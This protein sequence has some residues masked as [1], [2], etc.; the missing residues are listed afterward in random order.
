MTLFHDV[1]GT[2]SDGA[3]LEGR[4]TVRTAVDANFGTRYFAN[5]SWTTTPGGNYNTRTDRDVAL[6]SVGVRL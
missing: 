3:F 4:I 1:N 6:F 2:S 5:M